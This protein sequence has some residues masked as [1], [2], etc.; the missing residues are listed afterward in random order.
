MYNIKLEF[1]FHQP[2]L[3]RNQ[4]EKKKKKNA[5]FGCIEIIACIL[6]VGF[7]WFRVKVGVKFSEAF[8]AL[9]ELLFLNTWFKKK[10][11]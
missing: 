7:S 9:E 5:T 4:E 2:S 1:F 3:L 11:P 10:N 6:W 8:V